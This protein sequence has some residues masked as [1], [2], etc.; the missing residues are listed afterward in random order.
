MRFRKDA[1][2][3]EQ[4]ARPELSLLSRSSLYQLTQKGGIPLY[5]RIGYRFVGALIVMNRRLDEELKTPTLI[6]VMA[7]AAE[8]HSYRHPLHVARR[9]KVIAGA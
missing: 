2:G 6:A 4:I 5:L 1:Y 7:I 9:K 3:C 8:K